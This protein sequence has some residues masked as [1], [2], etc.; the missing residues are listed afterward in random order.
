MML[1]HPR[2]LFCEFRRRF[3]KWTFVR[4][5]HRKGVCVSIGDCCNL[6]H[7]RIKGDEGCEIIIEDNCS[8]NYCNFY[9]KGKGGRIII[10]EGSLF[11]SYKRL[12]TNMFVRGETLI[13]IGRNCLFAHS[14]DISTTD[15][16]TVIDGDGT[17]TNVDSNVVIGDHVWIGKRTTINKGVTI[18]N[19]SVVG[20]SSVVTK[21]YTTPNV[22]IAGNPAIIKKQGINWRR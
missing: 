14:I 21:A 5:C 13:E 3:Q 4:L 22:L 15:Y 20:A 16:H 6:N 2:R 1:F 17:V 12:S 8:I 10:R 9:F 18:P 11:N 19:D 7:C